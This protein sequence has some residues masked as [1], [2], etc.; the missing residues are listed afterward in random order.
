MFFQSSV[1]ASF[2][3]HFVFNETCSKLFCKENVYENIEHLIN[4]YKS[5]IGLQKIVEKNQI[6]HFYNPSN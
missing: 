6:I 1:K 5:F 3:G 4:N 2:N